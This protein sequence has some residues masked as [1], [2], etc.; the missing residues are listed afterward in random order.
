MF[1]GFTEFDLEVAQTTIHGRY[2][3]SGPAATLTRHTVDARDVAPYRPRLAR[4]F[5]VATDYRQRL[6]A[7]RGQGL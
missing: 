5:T 6:P 2:G 7:T 3:G 4:D 1:E